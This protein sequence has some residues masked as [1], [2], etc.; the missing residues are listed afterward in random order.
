MQKIS[1]MDQFWIQ[2]EAE[3]GSWPKLEFVIISQINHMET[4]QKIEKYQ[5]NWNFEKTKK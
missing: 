4:L 2:K 1:K 3:G 5:K